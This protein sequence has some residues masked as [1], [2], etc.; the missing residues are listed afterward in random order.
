MS[1]IK[2]NIINL[3]MI[4]ACVGFIC[5]GVL[6]LGT[7]EAYGA[8]AKLSGPGTVRSGDTITLTLSVSD[9]GKYGLEGAFDYDS[10]KVTLNSVQCVKNGW[11]VERN[12]NTIIAYDD[13]MTSPLGTNTSLIKAVFK[14]KA[15]L[16]AGTTV[17]IA[18]K[19]I[20]TTTG[21]VEGN[22]GNATY[23]ISL[24]KSLSTDNT[25]AG[26]TVTGYTLSP[27]FNSNTTS[28]SIGQVDYSV[29]K[30]NVNATKADANATVTVTG[31][32]LAVGNNTV[33]VTVKAQDGSTKTYNISV[34]RK[35]NPNYVAG[36]NANISSATVSSG[37]LSPKFDP[38]VTG[39]VVYL[40]Y[41]EVGTKW[42]IKG[43][44]QDSKAVGVQS[45]VIDSLKEG[46]NSAKLICTAEDGST[47][48]YNVT[49]VVMP[50]YSGGEPAT[51]ENTGDN[52]S[53]GQGD[54]QGNA[55]D[56]TPDSDSNS[57]GSNSDN[58]SSHTSN[59]NTN[60]TP[61]W[62]ILLFVVIA[63]VAGFGLCYV[64]FSKNV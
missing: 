43:V 39:Y 2:K 47:K 21:S 64:I 30:L 12:G 20:V 36:A 28:Y 19:N 22:L 58:D 53:D 59:S 1:N 52:D 60:K 33:K 61:I 54:G 11:K 5:A 10:S 27:A 40:P 6:E 17:N 26:L 9:S 49:V 38:S 44:A 23:S 15:G 3:L 8:S 31:T 35:Q 62:L 7:V 13:A 50:K 63:A 57:A 34:T 24:A 29:T 18:L 45:G 37:K 32:N 46:N 41:E 14:V 51:W 48:T 42:E 55:G 4:I 56:L 16:E 25:L